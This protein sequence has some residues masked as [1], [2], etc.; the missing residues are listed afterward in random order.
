MSRVSKRSSCTR[1]VYMYNHLQYIY[2]C[3]PIYT[4]A[5]LHTI[6][7]TLCM[8]TCDGLR[9][10]FGSSTDLNHSDELPI[11]INKQSC[12]PKTAYMVIMMCIVE[13]N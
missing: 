1:M 13:K 8:Q 4:R 7:L 2:A 6:C 10:A 3:M 11:K 5:I 9:L 12:K